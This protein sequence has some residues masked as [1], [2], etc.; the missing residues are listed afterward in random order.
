MPLCARGGSG[1]RF[2]AGAA[3]RGGNRGRNGPKRRFRK[4]KQDAAGEPSFLGVVWSDYDCELLMCSLGPPGLAGHDA[5][6]PAYP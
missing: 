2:G 5:L 4:K 1:V 3:L 6:P